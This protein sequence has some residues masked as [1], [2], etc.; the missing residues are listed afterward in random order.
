MTRLVIAGAALLVTACAAGA[1]VPV[2]ISLAA[3]ASSVIAGRAWTATLTARP[4]SFAGV[5]RVSAAGPSELNVRATGG[6][7]TYRARLVFPAAGR[8]TLSAKAGGSTSRLGTITV[9]SPA[10]K[11]LTFT[12]PTSIDLQ[13]DGSLLVVENG[14]GRLDRVQPATGRVTTIASGLAKPY[15]VAS[16]ASGTIYLSNGG[17]LQRIDGTAAPVT[18]LDAGTDV[19]PIALAPSGG[20]FYTTAAQAFALGAGWLASGLSGPHGIAVAADGAVLVC[21]TGNGAVLRIDPQTHAMTTLFRTGEPRGV[22]VAADGSVYVVEA[23]TKRVGHY[24]ATGTRL[25]DVG[26]VFNDPYDVEVGADGTVFVL[27]TAESGTIRRIAP[28]G[29]VATLSTG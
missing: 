29:S 16:T 11:P 28:D 7:G 3:K 10:P 27:E 20:V 18:V 9:R 6:R 14:A 4:R 8:W 22:D 13:P 24:T 15:A 2:R 1:A 26:P 17:S 23:G 25:G 12:W 19:G 5:V 21:D